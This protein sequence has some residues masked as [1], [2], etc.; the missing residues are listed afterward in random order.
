MIKLDWNQSP[1]WAEWF[2]VD[3]DG[4][5]WWYETKPNLKTKYGVWR[6]EF[7]PEPNIYWS[8]EYAGN[9]PDAADDW[10]NSLKKRPAE[11]EMNDRT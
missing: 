9:Y 5:A 2:A 4:E 6:H 8:C 1:L 7:N 11:G 3:N 10:Q